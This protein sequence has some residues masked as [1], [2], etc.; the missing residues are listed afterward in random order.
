MLEAQALQLSVEVESLITRYF[1]TLGAT[2]TED[3]KK[4]E[5]FREQVV[6]MKLPQNLFNRIDGALQQF[7]RPHVKTALRALVSRGT[8]TR[9]HVSA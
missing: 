3:A 8:I 9:Q 1:A 2:S 6:E 5:E 7:S 4:I